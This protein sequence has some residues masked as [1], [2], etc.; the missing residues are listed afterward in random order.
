M[1]SNGN[2]N[3]SIKY[4]DG[5]EG[6]DIVAGGNTIVQVTKGSVQ[7]NKQLILDPDQ[8]MTIGSGTFSTA[9]ADTVFATTI[10]NTTLA[11]NRVVT[12]VVSASQGIQVT[13]SVDV[14]QTGT[15]GSV[16]VRGDVYAGGGFVGNFV[17]SRT[18]I[19]AGEMGVMYTASPLTGTATYDA[20]AL[21]S[22]LPVFRAG[23]LMGLALY[24]PDCVV[25]SANGG[26]LTAS[27]VVGSTRIG[28]DLVITTGSVGYLAFAK[29]TYSLSAGSVI[30][31]SFTASSG[32]LND[33]AASGSWV[34][35]AWFEV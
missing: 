16:S 2:G 32:Y 20:R 6:W 26:A 34:A 33:L 1:N 29:D 9:V 3:S 35:T 31:V 24:S 5:T 17:Y 21:R 28:T 15:F 14:S 12:Q 23:S 8:P 22:Q 13:G 18:G 19:K 11:N 4:N 25:K 10:F 27:L 7:I 30:G